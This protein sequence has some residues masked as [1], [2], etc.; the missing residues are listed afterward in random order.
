MTRD[1]G[2]PEDW[3]GQQVVIRE[4]IV[5]RNGNGSNGSNKI[6][7]AYAGFSTVVLLGV[8]GWALTKVDTMSERLTRVEAIVEMM[9]TAQGLKV[10]NE[11]KK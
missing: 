10:P 1:D 5:E 6:V 4:R 9:A 8:T 2:T 11:R 7:W 3:V